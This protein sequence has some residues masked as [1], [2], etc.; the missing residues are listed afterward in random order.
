MNWGVIKLTLGEKMNWFKGKII[1]TPVFKIY[2]NW[3]L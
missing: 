3:S 1:K 2:K